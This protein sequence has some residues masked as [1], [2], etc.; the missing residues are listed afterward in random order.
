[1]R[2]RRILGAD[3]TLTPEEIWP[4]VASGRAITT[5]PDYLVDSVIAPTGLVAVPLVDVEPFT[6]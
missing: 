3:S 6:I 1:V 5:A 2:C 4:I